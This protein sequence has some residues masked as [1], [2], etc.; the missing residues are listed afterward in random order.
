MRSHPQLQTALPCMMI[1]FPAVRN[2]PVATHVEN[3]GWGASNA[4]TLSQCR[5][6]EVCNPQSSLYFRGR[7]AT[8]SAQLFLPI[9]FLIPLPGIKLYQQADGEIIGPQWIKRVAIGA[10]RRTM[11]SAR[12]DHLPSPPTV[13]S[14][15]RVVHLCLIQG[16]QSP[17]S[18][19]PV[20]R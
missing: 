15:K 4:R 2:S 3:P 16:Q 8:T 5:L 1:W 13:F 17:T 7:E 18:S 6:Y 11:S 19:S 12:G 9:S 14:P 20:E 10:N